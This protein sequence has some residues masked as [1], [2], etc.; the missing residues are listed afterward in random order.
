MKILKEGNLEKAKKPAIFT[1]FDCGC[2]FEANKDEYRL[3]EGQRDYYPLC[4]CP[5]CG[6]VSAGKFKVFNK[7]GLLEQ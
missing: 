7:Y 1:C 5:C 4:D 3:E 2:Q 6:C